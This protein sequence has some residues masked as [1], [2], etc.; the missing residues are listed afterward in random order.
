MYTVLNYVDPN[1]AVSVKLDV[2]C[3]DGGTIKIDG[4]ADCKHG[5]YDISG[6]ALKGV[7]LT[8]AKGDLYCLIASDY[9]RYDERVLSGDIPKHEVGELVRGYLYH[10]G[11]RVTVE[12]ALF[13][14]AVVA[15]D[16]LV[17]VAGTTKLKKDDGAGVNAVAKVLEVKKYMGRDVVKMIM[18]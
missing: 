4:L 5:T 8:D 15:G 17:P 11:Q 2:E 1:M 3:E 18:L 14:G 16:L 13:D 9:H 10:R 6:E 12:K 7:S